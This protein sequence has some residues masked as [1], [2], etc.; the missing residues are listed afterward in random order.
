MGM[1]NQDNLIDWTAA[2]LIRHDDLGITE[3]EARQL[4]QETLMAMDNTKVHARLDW[5]IVWAQK[6]L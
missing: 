4:C 2:L 6:P 3:E 1:F 5:G